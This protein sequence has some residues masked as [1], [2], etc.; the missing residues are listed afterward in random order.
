MGIIAWTFLAGLLFGENKEVRMQVIIAVAFATLG[1]HFAS[2]YMGDTLI[3][4]G[5]CPPMFHPAT[6]WFI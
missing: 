1:E 2:I 5:M 3:G 6:E 4:L